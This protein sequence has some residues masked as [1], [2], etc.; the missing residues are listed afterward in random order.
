MIS[1]VSGRVAEIT[2]DSA[3]IEVG[4]IG[5][6]LHCTP[7]TLAGLRLGEKATL[8]STLIVREDSLTLYGFADADERGAFDILIGITGIGP[9]I[10]Q[11]VLAVLTAEQLRTAVATEDLATL[12][13][14]PGIG[15][16]SAERMVLELRDRLGPPRGGS[17]T[18]PAQAGATGD[19]RR[20]Q[21]H[22][23]LTNLGWSA[24]DAEAAWE[25]AIEQAGGDGAVP[26]LLRLALQSLG[27]SA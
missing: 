13:K 24:R 9:R 12:C 20:I 7:G 3:V 18:V 4:G 23:A 2:V 10:A 25:S 15:K 6:S 26:D 17:A 8:P 11:A 5:L 16:K 27:R 14:V 21:V 22:G 1:F 19:E